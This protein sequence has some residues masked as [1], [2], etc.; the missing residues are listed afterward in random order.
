M[1]ANKDGKEYRGVLGLD[2][3]PP[4]I[5]IVIWLMAFF[6]A[7]QAMDD[8]YSILVNSIWRVRDRFEWL[9]TLGLASPPLFLAGILRL[10]GIKWRFAL[11]LLA[12]A[13]I[14]LFIQNLITGII[15]GLMGG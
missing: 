7:V 9:V 4:L 12:A 2:R 15:W 11:L 3:I 8:V 1:E 5:K 13:P 10:A 6:L 14:T